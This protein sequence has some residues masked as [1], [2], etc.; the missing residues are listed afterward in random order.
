MSW[1]KRTI[2]I[3]ALIGLG[4]LAFVVVVIGMIAML[5]FL[6]YGWLR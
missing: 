3:A 2:E 5:V 1:R 6:A 4:A